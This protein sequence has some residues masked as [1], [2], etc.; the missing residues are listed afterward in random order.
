MNNLPLSSPKQKTPCP[1]SQ[2]SQT[3]IYP[4]NKYTVPPTRSDCVQRADE[5]ARSLRA[6]S[7][8]ERSRARSSTSAMRGLPSPK[9]RRS[10]NCS[11]QKTYCLNC[12][13]VPSTT[14]H[15]E[16]VSRSPERSEGEESPF[17]LPQSPKTTVPPVPMSQSTNRLKLHVPTVAKSQ[18]TNHQK[19][20]SQV[21][22]VS[23][24]LQPA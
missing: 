9:K 22:N 17:Q 12:R 21:P 16:R 2:T 1:M 23:T 19:L 15:S 13:K 7:P 8:G 14:Y 11:Y 18:T 4:T 6:S 10:K 3:S 24:N 20:V 5:L